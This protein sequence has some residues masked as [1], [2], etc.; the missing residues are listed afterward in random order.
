M[1]GLGLK[2]GAW[3]VCSTDDA[4]M[5]MASKINEATRFNKVRA[6]QQTFN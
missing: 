4:K 2:Q 6:L 3:V 1:T 5:P